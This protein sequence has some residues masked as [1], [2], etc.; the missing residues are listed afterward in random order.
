MQGGDILFGDLDAVHLRILDDDIVALHDLGA[1]PRAF[2]PTASIFRAAVD[3]V[4]GQ[5]ADS[6][7]AHFNA[8]NS[9]AGESGVQ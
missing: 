5:I 1:L 2:L 8:V 7:G 9:V 3:A 6:E 4:N